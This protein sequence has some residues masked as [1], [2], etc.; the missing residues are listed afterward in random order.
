MKS[1]N[2]ILPDLINDDQK[3]YG[4]CFNDSQ[5][6]YNQMINLNNPH[7]EQHLSSTSSWEIKT[8]LHSNN[9]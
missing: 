3:L 7:T 4:L 6:L 1:Q 8:N 2:D 5:N 9:L